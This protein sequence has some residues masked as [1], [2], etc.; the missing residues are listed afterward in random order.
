MT[1]IWILMGPPG[2]GKGTQAAM[3]KERQGYAHVSTGAVFRQEIQAGSE[4]GILADELISAGN[5]VPDDITC[6]ILERELVRLKGSS[7]VLLDGF[8]RTLA[9]AQALETMVTTGLRGAI[10]IDVPEQALIE[11]LSARR[12]C[13]VCGETF[14][15]SVAA[16]P[17][18]GSALE[19]RSDDRPEAIGTRLEVYRKT[20]MPLISYYGEQ[21]K[22][23]KVDG[24]GDPE[25]IYGRLEKL[26]V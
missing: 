15:D 22:L 20:T 1:D 8:P 24:V 26:L 5:L 23:F 19:F 16:C 14:N 4:L 17:K 6:K 13:P 7:G 11:R 3:L 2:S 9:Q 25:A 21:K 12:V 10:L 18:D